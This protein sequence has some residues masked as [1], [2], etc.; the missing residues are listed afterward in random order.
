M[1][2]SGPAIPAG[3][4]R[5]ETLDRIDQPISEIDASPSPGSLTPPRDHRVAKC[6]VLHDPRD[7]LGDLIRVRRV[8]EDRGLP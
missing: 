8:D 1:F 6:P 3:D 2:D 4:L 7:P 5:F